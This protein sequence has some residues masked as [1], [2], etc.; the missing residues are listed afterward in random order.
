MSNNQFTLRALQPSDSSALAK[1][2]TEFDSDM[3]TRFL[4]DSYTAI[5]SGTEFRTSGVV[6]DCEGFDGLVGM[7]TV[8]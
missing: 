5:V 1:L 7:G 8:R 2:I 4:V 6:V 3:T